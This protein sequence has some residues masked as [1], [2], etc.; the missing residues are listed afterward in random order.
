ML[1]FLKTPLEPLEHQAN[2]NRLVET[3]IILRSNMRNQETM[4]E[5]RS[6][7]MNCKLASGEQMIGSWLERINFACADLK[8]GDL[9]KVSFKKDY[10]FYTKNI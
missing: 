3:L 8:H 7:H 10:I 9:L 4:V 2:L 6:L 5:A 1:S